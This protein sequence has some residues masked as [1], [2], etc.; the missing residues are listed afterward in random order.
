MPPV[1][2]FPFEGEEERFTTEGTEFTE[3]EGEEELTAEGAEV[4]EAEVD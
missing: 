2:P 3:R 1:V 4:T